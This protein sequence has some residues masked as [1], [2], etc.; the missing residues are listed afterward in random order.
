[1]F[2]TGLKQ[3][4]AIKSKSSELHIAARREQLLEVKVIMF[5]PET[6]HWHFPLVETDSDPWS[7]YRMAK[8]KSAESP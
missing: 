1:M 2:Y 6:A 7:Y 5:G 8:F 4:S 3:V